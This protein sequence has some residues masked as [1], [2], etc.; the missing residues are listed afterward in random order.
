VSLHEHWEQQAHAWAAWARKPGHDSYRFVRDLFFGLVVPPPGAATLDLG[1]GEGR[2]CR[3]LHARGHRM[4]GVDLSPTLI[5][6]AREADPESAYVRADATALPF[7][8]ASFDLVVS[9]NTLMNFDDLDAALRESARVLT[10]DGRLAICIV[11]PMAY[12]YRRRGDEF[13]FEPPYFDR[14]DGWGTYTRDGLTM[15]FVD[16]SRTLAEYS[17]ALEGAGFAIERLREISDDDPSVRPQFMFMR[18]VKRGP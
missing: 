4:T 16:R 2:V 18:C 9:Y 7:A 14:P 1:C 8:D 6:Y 12:V 17:R 13:V 3:D 11:H 10:L 5:D 15:T